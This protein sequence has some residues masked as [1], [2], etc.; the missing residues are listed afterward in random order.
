[1]VSICPADTP[2]KFHG[3]FIGRECYAFNNN[4]RRADFETDH[5]ARLIIR[6]CCCQIFFDCH[7]VD[8]IA[9]ADKIVQG[10]DVGIDPNQ[11]EET[12][13]LGKKKPGK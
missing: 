4:H 11:G 5:F 12:V 10:G 3:L 8:A 6:E 1:M 2:P 13:F 7:N 9:V